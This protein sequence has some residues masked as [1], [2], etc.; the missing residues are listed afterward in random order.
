LFGQLLLF[1]WRILTKSQP[2][3][4]IQLRAVQS[5]FFSRLLLFCC[6]AEHHRTV[7]CFATI[8]NWLDVDCAGLLGFC[9]RDQL[10]SSL[11]LSLLCD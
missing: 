8:T 2:F 3:S 7:V 1:S 6:W 4:S 11:L 10:T 5:L 9:L